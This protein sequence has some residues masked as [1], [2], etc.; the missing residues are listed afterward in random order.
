MNYQKYLAGLGTLAVL[1]ALFFGAQF[2]REKYVPINNTN[3]PVATNSDK[4]L[5]EN[6]TLGFSFELPK[7]KYP[8]VKV[9]QSGYITY[10][11]LPTKDKDWNA[12]GRYYANAFAIAA[13]PIEQAEKNRTKCQMGQMDDPY[14]CMPFTSSIGKNKY[15]YF[16]SSGP[17]EGPA[18]FITAGLI[19][20]IKQATDHLTVFDPP[21][22]PAN[23]TMQVFEK[24]YEYSYPAYLEVSDYTNFTASLSLPAELSSNDYITDKALA[25]ILPV[26]Y[27]ALSGICQP[28]TTNFAVYIGAIDLT[29]KNLL[30][31]GLGQSVTKTTVGNYSV[32][33]YE[34]GAEGEGIIYY[35]L[36]GSN[37]K[38]TVVALRYMNEQ[39]MARYQ[40]VPNFV[41]Y[42]DQ[43]KTTEKIIQSLKFTTP[44]K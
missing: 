3:Q 6:K 15:F 40:T 29:E 12:Q 8:E 9:E 24:G 35:F 16:T 21:S 4:N 33:K 5:I 13:T 11:Y 38:M 43:I 42:T 32:Y 26:Q 7:N 39:V 20:G 18:E 2:L 27:C 19:D 23:L 31:S 30:Q 14:A 44:L 25:N 34:Q 37:K 28:T 1:A 10:I 22:K 41:K 36:F 17:Q